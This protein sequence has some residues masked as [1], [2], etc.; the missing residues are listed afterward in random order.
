MHESGRRRR[1]DVAS[2]YMW[3]A[4]LFDSIYMLS[5]ETQLNEKLII[6][7]TNTD[8]RGRQ[9]NPEVAGSMGDIITV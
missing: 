5:Y 3:R 4:Q 6:A 8:N 9:R 1:V 7:D 2:D